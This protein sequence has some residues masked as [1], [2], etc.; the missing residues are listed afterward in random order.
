M[1]TA[2]TNFIELINSGCPYHYIKMYLNDEELDVSFKSFTYYGLINSGDSISIGNTCASHIEFELYNQ[3]TSLENKEVQ[4]KV[5]ID[6]NGTIEEKSLGF[7]T[8]TKPINND[9]VSKYT[10]Y[11]RMIKLEKLY[12]SELTNPTTKSVMNEIGTQLGYGFDN[13][14]IEIPLDAEKIKG[15]TYREIVGYISA[16]YGAN[17]VINDK[18]QIEFKWYNQTD[19]TVERNRMYENGLELSSDTLFKVGYIKCATGETVERTTTDDEGEEITE[20]EDII[21]SVGNGNTGITLS[22]P[23]M[24]QE[25]L[26]NVYNTYFANFEYQPCKVNM[27]GNILVECGD[28]VTVDNGTNTY[29]MPIMNITH[30]IDGGIT[31][32]I[33]AIAQTESEQ[34]INYEGPLVQK[35]DRIYHE[36][37][38]A[39][40]ILANEIKSSNIT[41]DYLEANYA[42]IQKLNAINATINNLTTNK[43]DIDFANI[44]FAN[45]QKAKLGELYAE[46]GLIKNLQVEN[47]TITGEL[48]A[49]R[50]NGDL[51]NANTIVAKSLII[52]GENGLFYELN[53]NI[54]GV[55][56]EQLSTE[57]YQEKLHGD[58]IIANTITANHIK[59]NSL[60]SNEIQAR[61]IKAESLDVID[62]FAQDITASGTIKGVTLEG[63]KYVFVDD[64]DG[65]MT[66][67]YQNGSS[68]VWKGYDG[69]SIEILSTRSL[70]LQ[71]SIALS[72][73]SQ[74]I[75]I[76]GDTN[77]TG[78][79]CVNNNT[80]L[81][82]SN[83]TSYCA[84]AS[85]T[86]TI[87][88]I[89]N[90]QATLDGKANTHSHPYLS[91]SGGT[92]S[93]TLT[94][95][96]TSSSAQAIV[97]ANA[98]YIYGKNTSGTAYSIAGVSG[99]N[100]I[101]FGHSDYALNTNV[102][103]ATLNLRSN[104]G[105]TSNSGLTFD[106]AKYIKGK[107]TSGTAY[108]IL[109]LGSGNWVAVG[110]SNFVTG[111]RGSSV[112]LGSSSGTVVTS[113]KNLKTD[114][115]DVDSRYIDFFKKLRPVTYKYE[116]G[117]SGR[118][119]IGFIAQE[120]E[121][122]L[123]GVGLTTD[124]FG[125]V[126]ID[127][128]IY[129]KEFEDD[130]YDDM[131]YAYN[132]GLKKVY[133]LRY[134][135]FI[136]LNSKMTQIVMKENEV[137]KN[138]VFE[139]ETTSIEKDKK[140]SNLEERIAKLE[141]LIANK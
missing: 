40:K 21:L 51:I 137:L 23:L 120:V 126:C 41:T 109:G 88:N 105:I 83:Y 17:C 140:I 4:I 75:S 122:A 141:A 119:H 78:T 131:N 39:N 5:G 104:S 58:N 98:K 10:A 29:I 34:S 31:T 128:V 11:D 24:T 71:G 139:L 96:G 118:P 63:A 133:S 113:D 77:I 62:L 22:N 115:K 82:T 50:I 80:V 20:T 1:K 49:I 91:T 134:E 69:A 6:V 18:G 114:I 61:S 103:G 72:L 129:A 123:N 28:I 132:K 70:A 110:N 33:E 65:V 107:N 138:K 9:E 60:T 124:D 59:A 87:S 79:L 81:D 32:N 25:I 66:E 117:R 42:S 48:N 47:E 111:L 73:K 108:D 7:F 19:V 12:V 86:H 13:E 54:D 101:F 92:L 121:E 94:V 76:I 38:S 68:T 45:I 67:I 90:L 135:E 26:N 27:L 37:L 53:S 55:T 125:G 35:I 74:D 127:D 116:V 136:S 85:H 2:T 15:Y 106:N 102:Y 57:E 112:R 30:S 95:N 130:L 14:L 3:T 99:S 97:L 16:L 100:N 43:A 56:Q 8:I 84:K 93:G 46:S 52:E 36:L 89:T 44:N 64:T